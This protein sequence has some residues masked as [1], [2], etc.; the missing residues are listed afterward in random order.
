M[1]NVELDSVELD[2][3]SWTT[4]ETVSILTAL[5]PNTATSRNPLTTLRWST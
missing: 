2:S 3:T 4:L 1:P 5:N